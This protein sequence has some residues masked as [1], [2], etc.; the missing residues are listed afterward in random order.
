MVHSSTFLKERKISE[1]LSTEKK[2]K[3]HSEL[4]P[5]LLH[6]ISTY[7]LLVLRTLA[8]A[9]PPS[10]RVWTTLMLSALLMSVSQW[11]LV[12]QSQRTTQ[13]WSLLRTTSRPP[14]WE[15]CGA[16]TS[17][18]T[19]EDSS[20]SK[21]LS[22]SPLS[23]SSCWDAPPRVPPHSPLFSCFGSTWLWTLLLPSHLAQRDHTPTSLRMVQFK[24]KIPSSLPQCWSKSTEWLYISSLSLLFF[25]S[26]LITLGVLTTTTQILCTTPMETQPTR[27][28]FTLW[29][30]TPSCGCTSSTSSTAVK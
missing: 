12:S 6:T 27:M 1:T 29:S 2:P 16:E 8:D 5:E 20:S 17:T 9:L 25:T 22:T 28:L 30:S 23:C 19:W 7:S 4:L 26:S 18:W 24:T 15:L 10:V 13:I 21:S 11:A 14:W 3:S